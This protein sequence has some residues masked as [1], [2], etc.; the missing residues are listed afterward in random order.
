MLLGLA[1]GL[2]LVQREHGQLCSQLADFEGKV[3]QELGIGV[4]AVREQVLA[5]LGLDMA[6]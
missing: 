5:D 2:D 6:L 3:A 1:D 4:G